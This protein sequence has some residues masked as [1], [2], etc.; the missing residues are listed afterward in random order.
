MFDGGVGQETTSGVLV[1]PCWRRGFFVVSLPVQVLAFGLWELSS[2]CSPSGD[3]SVVI[4]VFLLTSSPLT[5]NQDALG[6][7]LSLPP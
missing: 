4:V 1:P 2:L 5:A 6:I 7:S 3:G